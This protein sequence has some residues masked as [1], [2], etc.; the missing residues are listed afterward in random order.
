MI[1]G[2]PQFLGGL[3]V[4]PLSPTSSHDLE[5]VWWVGSKLLIANPARGAPILAA[6][7]L[8]HLSK[9]ASKKSSTLQNSVSNLFIMFALQ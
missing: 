3:L 7:P 6:S 5:T 1:A 4:G 2:S 8:G 9:R